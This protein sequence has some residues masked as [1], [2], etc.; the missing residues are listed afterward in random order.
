MIAPAHKVRR[1][2]LRY[3]GGKWLLAPW[4]ISHFPVHRVYTEA[5]GGAAS[6]LIRKP[7]CYGEVYND[8]DGEIVSLFRVLRDPA[9]SVELRRMLEATPFARAEFDESY[10][11]APDPVEAARRT[12]IRSFMGFGS[13]GVTGQSK[14]GFRATSNRS[15]T[16]PAHDWVNYSEALPFLHA[17]L[18]DVVIEHR[19][20][21]DL[22]RQQDGVETLH[23]VDPPYVAATR[24]KGGFK[25]YR[26]EMTD[27]DHEDLA[28][29]LKGLTGMVVLSGYNS[30]LY[31]ELFA[32]WAR[33]AKI[34]LADG[35][36]SRTE[37]LWMN[38]AAFANQQSPML[39]GVA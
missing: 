39:G 14:T 29:C 12:I 6:V 33:S 27:A 16:T 36:K 22:L 17:R 18:A 5:F 15:G 13:D 30:A 10:K 38:E 1:P 23:Y 3:H 9:Q 19:D 31:G 26:H 35:A 20:A 28:T 37:I 8:L 32:G 34:T 11:P 4:I 2:A 7:K 25:R 21:L 24:S